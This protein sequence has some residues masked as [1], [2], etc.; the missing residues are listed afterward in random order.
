M[1]PKLSSLEQLF[2][3]AHGF[4]WLWIHIGLGEKD[5]Y[6]L[7]GVWSLSWEGLMGGCDNGWGLD[8][9]WRSLFTHLMT[10]VSYWQR[11]SAGAVSWSFPAWASSEH[12]DLLAC[13]VGFNRECPSE[14]IEYTF[15]NLVESYFCLAQIDDI[16]HLFMDFF[17]IHV[18]SLVKCPSQSLTHFWNRFFICFLLYPFLL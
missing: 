3:C 8:I 6:L 16:V 1:T 14:F 10:D 9:I 15:L 7:Q 2:Y 18:S 17:A 4:C 12:R 11:T 5:L 13:Q